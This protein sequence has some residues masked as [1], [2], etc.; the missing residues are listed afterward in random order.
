V[1]FGRRIFQGIGLFLPAYQ[2]YGHGVPKILGFVVLPFSFLI[3]VIH[4]FI[5]LS[6]GR[7]TIVSLI[8]LMS[9]KNRLGFFFFFAIV[10]NFF[11]VAL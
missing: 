11:L 8:L 7:L 4:N 2:V 10:F 1:I 5:L 3:L 6:L 9:S